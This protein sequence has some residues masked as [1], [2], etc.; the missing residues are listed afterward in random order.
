M[1]ACYVG[2]E[3][4]RRSSQKQ[5]P[6]LEWCWIFWWTI[7]VLQIVFYSTCIFF[8]WVV[9]PAPSDCVIYHEMPRFHG[10]HLHPV[11]RR[12]CLSTEDLSRGT[13]KTGDGSDFFVL[14]KASDVYLVNFWLQNHENHEMQHTHTHIYHQIY[15]DYSDISIFSRSVRSELPPQRLKVLVWESMSHAT[16]LVDIEKMKLSSLGF[17]L[18]IHRFFPLVKIN[19]SLAANPAAQRMDICLFRIWIPSQDVSNKHFT[20][21]FLRETH[22]PQSSEKRQMIYKLNQI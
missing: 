2:E 9:Q 6:C 21:S 19:C 12:L 7:L 15:S 22:P 4:S 1:V 18:F 13:T 5:A 10:L 14:E 8:K 20:M 3:V 17:P 11:F 16:I